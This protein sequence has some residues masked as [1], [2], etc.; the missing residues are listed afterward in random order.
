MPD[1]TPLEETLYAAVRYALDRAQ[2]DP[3]FR[4]YMLDTEAH[5]RLV[6]A[7]AAY[8]GRDVAEVMAERRL[9]KQPPYRTRQPDVVRFRDRLEELGEYP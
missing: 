2:T 5:H 4:H 1:H 8:L 3:D 6:A 9:D 7:E